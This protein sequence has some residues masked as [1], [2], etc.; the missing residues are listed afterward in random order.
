MLSSLCIFFSRMLAE[1]PLFLQS[2][3]GHGPSSMKPAPASAVADPGTASGTQ[4]VPD[5]P[6][7]LH[8]MW[9]GNDPSNHNDTTIHVVRF[10]DGRQQQLATRNAEDATALASAI[11]EASSG[12]AILLIESVSQRCRAILSTLLSYRRDFGLACG[13]WFLLDVYFYG[14]G[15]WSSK[16][17][18]LI[19]FG[20]FEEVS[21]RRFEP[22]HTPHA[23]IKTVHCNA[24]FVC[25]FAEC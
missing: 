24:S 1:T 19:G 7:S 16:V 8:T 6:T 21:L 9:S 20:D 10:A 2:R 14:Q 23:D 3:K 22:L 13:S 17:L 11:P 15:L 18:V 25:V 5:T 4:A 12:G